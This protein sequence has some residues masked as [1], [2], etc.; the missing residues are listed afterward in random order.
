V[1]IEVNV[2]GIPGPIVVEGV[3]SEATMQEILKSIDKNGREEAK[4]RKDAEAGSGSGADTGGVEEVNETAG[5][6][7]RALGLLTAHV[8]YA[9]G[10]FVKLG[11]VSTQVI[12]HFA[13]VGD[14]VESAA[15]TFNGIPVVGTAFAAVA[16][17][18]TRAADSFN[19]VTAS[20]A[21]FGGS[22]NN[23]ARSAS[24]AGMTLDNF[25]G[26]IAKNGEGMLAFG[27]TTGEGAARFARLSRE[28]RATGSDLFALGF[29][30]KDINE[31]LGTFGKQIR[32]QGLQRGM[33]DRELIEGSQQYLK[34]MDKLAKITGETRK[35]KEA[36]REQLLADAQFQASMAG[37]QKDVRDSFL[38]TVQ[39][40]PKGMQD[41]TKDILAT[42]T[43]TQE[44]N[45][46]LLAQMPQTGALITQF[47]AKMQRG[48]KITAQEQERL[49]NLMMQEGPAA[50]ERL[51][52]AGAASEELAPLVNALASTLGMNADAVA[53]ATKAQEE[54]AAGSDGVN[55]ELNKSREQLAKITN[56][57]TMT[58]V[59]SGI[60]D[61]MLGTFTA[62]A[63][64][65]GNNVVPIF[66][67]F[68]DLIQNYAYPVFMG[69]M[70]ILNAFVMPSL[71]KLGDFVIGTVVPALGELFSIASAVLVPVLGFLGGII[72]DYVLPAF[73]TIASFI[74]DN[75][76][77]LF[78][79]LAAAGISYLG[80]LAAQRVATLLQIAATY[81]GILPALGAMAMAAFAAA[82]PILAVAAPFIAV[83]VAVA[84]VAAVMKSMYDAG[85]TL[86]GF[87]DMLGGKL[88][89]V[90]IFFEDLF[91]KIL[92]ALPEFM[93]GI[94]DSEAEERFKTLDEKR[95]KLADD[96]LAR[97]QARAIKAKERT[98]EVEVA[99]TDSKTTRT[100]RV[101]GKEV[102]EE[103]YKASQAQIAQT[104]SGMD[105][106]MDQG[107]AR[108]AN[109]PST[110][111]TPNRPT[112]P[113]FEM[114]E[115]ATPEVADVYQQT[116]ST[117]PAQEATE[118]GAS[119]VNNISSLIALMQQNNKLLSR[120]ISA[121]Q[122]LSGDLYK[123]IG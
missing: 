1:A 123:A 115:I 17:A 112:I 67:V 116:P 101:N 19:Q 8:G 107:I 23:M 121:T 2:P 29:S 120:Q 122:G 9:S 109:L 106:A 105:A 72:A 74:A 92:K 79:G 46:K 56:Q 44:E 26:L 60:L 91:I 15:A 3:A 61:E 59:E 49:R 16:S 90:G 81:G 80:V 35:E 66:N 98:G 108:N 119:S 89:Q 30:T 7:G 11:E 102:S 96:A 39:A 33:T 4:A 69:A 68:T 42:G 65:V 95:A 40:L 99:A 54:A 103:E 55:E 18:T 22:V 20:G 97:E 14:S 37:M 118:T 84:A 85:W 76:V 32:M 12:D 73:I 28:V 110:P 93:G 50:L 6:A 24:Q 52:F 113:D 51:K 100:Y 87:F 53:G 58:L 111:A 36:E 71:M 48:E 43:A 25:A 83:G 41:F 13:N 117:A 94:S 38:N 57:F 64:F 104:K 77:P 75:I 78:A 27:T 63:D 34:E 5:K 114:P 86:G 62:L 21:S 31:G 88:S 10:A 70:D 47:H 45:Q 82:A